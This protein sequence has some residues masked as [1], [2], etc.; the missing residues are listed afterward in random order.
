MQEEIPKDTYFTISDPTEG[1]YKDKGSKFLAYA[2]PVANEDDI[3]ERLEE[4]RKKHYDARHHC[5]AW[6]LG[7]DAENFRANDDGEPNHSAG[8]PILNQIRS[9][10]LSD[11]LVVVVRYFGGTKLGVSG[12][13][14]AYK[15]ATREALQIAEKREVVLKTKL[16]FH[17]EYEAMNEVMR[18]V[19]DLDLEVLEQ[20]FRQSCKLYCLI[21]NALIPQLES[22]LSYI[23]GL[24]S[25]ELDGVNESD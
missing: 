4:L 2:F 5:Y 19:K 10:E 13:I 14:Q 1:L 7:M 12:L 8:D 3:K 18:I 25:W 23:P 11:V 6:I 21:R 16:S 17:F 22:R 15:E 24:N 20:D 9:F